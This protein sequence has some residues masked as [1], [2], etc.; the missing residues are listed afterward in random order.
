MWGRFRSASVTRAIFFFFAGLVADS[1]RGMEEQM[2]REDEGTAFRMFA[3]L[4][5]SLERPKKDEDIDQMVSDLA[6]FGPALNESGKTHYDLIH[7]GDVPDALRSS[8]SSHLHRNALRRS[9][10]MGVLPTTASASD[11]HQSNTSEDIGSGD[12][13]SPLGVGGS[14]MK[15]METSP[16]PDGGEGRPLRDSG[17][18]DG[19]C[20]RALVLLSC[21]FNSNRQSSSFAAQVLASEIRLRHKRADFQ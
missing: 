21:S 8:G 16:S 3:H 4:S 13:D 2:D 9:Q 10:S 19:G 14:P 15:L 18:G 20:V 5:A 17:V 11:L 1:F 7:Y 6:D 12:S